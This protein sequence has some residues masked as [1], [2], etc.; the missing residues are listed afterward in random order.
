VGGVAGAGARMTTSLNSVVRRMIKDADA[1]HS[2]GRRNS[3]DIGRG[4]GGGNT[5]GELERRDQDERDKESKRREA[6]RVPRG[7]SLAGSYR[8]KETSA[9]R[10]V[11]S[12]KLLCKRNQSAARFVV[13]CKL[14][15]KTINRSHAH[16]THRQRKHPRHWHTHAHDKTPKRTPPTST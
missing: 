9:A 7:L 12:C 14:P 13:S 2:A 15:C 16:R 10:F 4:A 6:S 5:G 11:V 3:A 1:R 8:E